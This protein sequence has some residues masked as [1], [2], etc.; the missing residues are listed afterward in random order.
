MESSLSLYA[1]ELFPM[2]QM[3]ASNR[4]KS[5][6]RQ[7]R[8]DLQAHQESVLNALASD[9]TRAPCAALL[10]CH[11]RA[12]DALARVVRDGGLQKHWLHWPNWPDFFQYCVRVRSVDV[13]RKHVSHAAAVSAWQ[14][15]PLPQLYGLMCAA[16]CRGDTALCAFLRGLVDGSHFEHAAVVFEFLQ[17]PLLHPYLPVLLSKPL[18]HAWTDPT[19]EQTLLHAVCHQG[20]FSTFKQFTANAPTALFRVQDAD[21][22]TPFHRA[23][24]SGNGRVVHFLLAQHHS[25]TYVV[26][27]SLENAAGQVPLETAVLS[28]AP[29]HIV[30]A[31][32]ACCSRHD[33]QTIALKLPTPSKKR[34]KLVHSRTKKRKRLQ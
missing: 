23:V 4:T 21:G 34:Y 18:D 11:L 1:R 24:Q 10:L 25:N 9:A 13:V 19:T 30:D 7:H 17:D 5:L 6:L 14:Q 27:P 16:D 22:F 28:G 20:G 31:L 3:R 8:L 26:A 29:A 15:T 12:F 2:L 33:L 32:V